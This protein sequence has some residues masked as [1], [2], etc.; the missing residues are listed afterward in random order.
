[1]TGLVQTSQRRSGPD[2]FFLLQLLVGLLQSLLLQ[3]TFSWQ[4]TVSYSN[5]FYTPGLFILILSSVI[6]FCN[7]CGDGAIE[8]VASCTKSRSCVLEEHIS[9]RQHAVYHLF[10]E[11]WWARHVVMLYLICLIM[12]LVVVGW[13]KKSM[14]SLLCSVVYS[15]HVLH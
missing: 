4:I 13:F 11:I 15:V 5:Y 8:S 14:P 10:R 6:L 2:G 3:L 12:L 9:S 7:F 1:M